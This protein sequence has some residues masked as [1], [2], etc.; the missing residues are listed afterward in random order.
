M[1]LEILISLGAGIG[2]TFQEAEAALHQAKTKKEQ[3]CP[4]DDISLSLAKIQANIT[5][6][7]Y[8]IAKY[9]G[10]HLEDLPDS[11][12]TSQGKVGD[13][14]Q[15]TITNLDQ[16]KNN[17]GEDSPAYKIIFNMIHDQCY[18][19][20]TGTLTPFGYHFKLATAENHPTKLKR[21]C[22]IVDANDM[23]YWNSKVGYDRV[24]Q[25]LSLIG[26][27]LASSVRKND[28]NRLGDLVLRPTLI[29]RTHGSAGDEFLIDMYA[30][31][32][33]I[34]SII[35]RLFDNVYKAQLKETEKV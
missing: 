11:A 17:Y 18:D 14:V 23:H 15:K 22:I 19:F 12:Y 3:L 33:A 2:T 16:I 34:N 35:T 9:V 30:P 25:A 8:A 31:E 13:Q 4:T 28:N 10:P 26:Q 7:N 27:T 1:S 21:Y 24:T 6:K 29:S 32:D 20:N 5:S